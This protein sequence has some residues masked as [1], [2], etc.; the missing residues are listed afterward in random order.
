MFRPACH[1]RRAQF[2]LFATLHI[3]LTLSTNPPLIDSL[4]P[5]LIIYVF[6][7]QW[8]PDDDSWPLSR[9]RSSPSPQIAPPAAAARMMTNLRPTMSNPRQAAVHCPAFARIG[10]DPSPI[11]ASCAGSSFFGL[12]ADARALVCRHSAATVQDSS[13][14][15]RKNDC[16]SIIISTIFLTSYCRHAQWLS[17]GLGP[18][19]RMPMAASRVVPCPD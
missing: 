12:L 15:I 6:P 4:Q 17:H 16:C 5:S 8:P 3:H 13:Q 18:R 19:C 1:G 9:L 2:V 14:K 10:Y 7:R 11:L